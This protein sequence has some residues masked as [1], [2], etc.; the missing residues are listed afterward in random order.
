MNKTVFNYF[1]YIKHKFSFIFFIMLSLY[2][3]IKSV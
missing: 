2:I 1:K 3:C